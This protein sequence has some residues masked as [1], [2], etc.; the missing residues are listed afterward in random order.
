MA[1]SVDQLYG[2]EHFNSPYFEAF[3]NWLSTQS[4]K[5]GVEI[6]FAWGMSAHA[7]L[8]TQESDLISIDLNDHMGKGQGI[9]QVF[10]GRWKLVLGDSST[11]LLTLPGTFDYIYIDGDHNEGPVGADLLSAH[12]KLRKGGVIVCDDYGNPC[13]VKAAVDWFCETYN[14]SL[15]EMDSNPNGGVILRRTYA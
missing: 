14:Y 8:A 10:P 1:T 13:G 7:Y 11:T 2:A 12:K 4:F 3:K 9:E 5:R 6:G 15:E